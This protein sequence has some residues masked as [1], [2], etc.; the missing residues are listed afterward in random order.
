MDNLIEN[1]KREILSYN[2]KSP[3]SRFSIIESSVAWYKDLEKKLRR[4]TNGK[5]KDCAEKSL[6]IIKKMNIFSGAQI[7]QLQSVIDMYDVLMHSKDT[8][9]R[10]KAIR[11][12]ADHWIKLMNFEEYDLKQPNIMIILTAYMLDQAVNFADKYLDKYYTHPTIIM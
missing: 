2:K 7:E 11:K 3:D 10:D 8:F 9:E 4:I 1:L 12:R 6:K 5:D